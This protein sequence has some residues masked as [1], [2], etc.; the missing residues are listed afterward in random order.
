MAIFKIKV[1]KKKKNEKYKYNKIEILFNLLS[2]AIVFGVGIYFGARALYY[3]SRQNVKM[4]EEAMTLNG[5]ILNNNM[6]VEGDGLHQDSNGYYFKGKNPNNYVRFANRIFRAVRVNNDNSVKLISEEV[7]SS[8]MWGEEE[9]YENSNVRNWLTKTKLVHSGIYYNTIPS[10]NEFVVDTNYQIDKMLN[11]KIEFG[12][13]KLND[14]VSILELEEYVLA[15]GKNSYL[16]NGKTFY[17]LG[18]DEDDNYLYVDEEGNI[19]AIDS[20]AGYGVRPVFTLKGNTTI[21]SGIG[22]LEDPYVID[23]KDKINLIDSYVKLGNDIWKIYQEENGVLRMYLNDYI[24]TPEGLEVNRY[25]SK[26]N[27]M[28]DISENNSLSYYLNY[29]YI[30]GLSYKDVLLDTPFYLGEISDDTGHSFE[31]IYLKPFTFKVGLL[32]I[33]DYHNNFDKSDYFYI[34]AL[35]EVGN[36]QYSTNSTGFLI[37][38]DVREERHIVPVISIKKEIIK[39]GNGSIDNPFVIE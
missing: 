25:Y 3:Y 30:S 36:M 2:I 34:N 26:Y 18:I 7:V 39:N 27:C 24:K 9:K 4:Q 28:F 29:V 19:Q 12:N 16:N 21:T 8:F 13:Q 6:I 5:L 38:E 14:R 31:N 35:S 17:L 22:T 32:N 20:Y 15:G 10:I 11:D 33:F 23:Q 37:E 1:K